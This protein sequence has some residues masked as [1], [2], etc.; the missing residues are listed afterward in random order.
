MAA[1]PVP[2]EWLQLGAPR[3]AVAAFTE[4]FCPA[5][6]TPLWPVMLRLGGK[7]TLPLTWTEAGH[8]DDC[9]EGRGADWHWSVFGGNK[10]LTAT[11]EA[12]SDGYP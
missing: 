5:H 1:C 3:D 7:G 6:K 9:C 10:L 4:G 12:V 2:R 11:Y 8:C